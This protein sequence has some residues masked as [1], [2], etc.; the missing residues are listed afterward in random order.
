MR[1]RVLGS[2]A[3]G[4]FPQWNCRCAQCQGVRSGTIAARPR[5]QASLAVSSD[6]DQWLLLG[7][8]PDVGRQIDSAPELAPRRDGSPIAAVA[9]PNGDVDAWAGLLS[10]REWTPL[11][12]F[13]TPVVRED[14]AGDNGALGTLARFVGHSRWIDLAAGVRVRA[15]GD[16]SIEAIPLAGKPPLHRME[17]RAAD[18]LDNVGF[19]VRDERR[20]TSLAWLPSVAGPSPALERA[21]REVDVLFFDGTFYRDDELIAAGRGDRRARAMGHWPVDGEDGSAAFL[22]SLPAR[23]KW[24]VHVNNTNP[25]LV[26]D[27]P[28]RAWLRTIG[29][30]VAW[31]GLVWER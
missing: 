25:L 16:L 19:V 8:S 11:R 1:A 6:G 2:A 12:I 10:L 22:A 15:V 13:A 4:G 30:D 29:L 3:G 5:T 17:L 28:E 14:V 26:D 23:D 27:G 18:P 20:G 24:F 9:L 31:D 7:A 21:L